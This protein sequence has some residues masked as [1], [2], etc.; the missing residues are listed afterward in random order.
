M[1]TLKFAYTPPW[2][3]L[4]VIVFTV[5]P[6]FSIAHT[7]D[8]EN[9]IHVYEKAKSTV[10]NIISQSVSYDFFMTPIPQEGSG[11]GSIIDLNGHIVTNYH[12][13]QGAQRLDVTLSD[14]TQWDA[15]LV[16]TDP[17]SD[18]AI[19]R[20]NAPHN[21]LSV[22]PIGDSRFLKTGQKV[23]AIG[24]PFGLEQTLTTGVVSSIR[25]TLQAGGVELENVIQTDAAINPGNSGGPLLHS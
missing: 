11:S 2:T 15:E 6:Q 4:A 14:G 9:T 8:E 20:I 22:A 19:L 16:G 17:L 24:N 25:K 5:L 3:L 7:K 13:V 23:L 1:N 12:V 21:R 18:L 10:V